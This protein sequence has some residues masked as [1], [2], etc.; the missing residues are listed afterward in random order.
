MNRD[1]ILANVDDV[2][3]VYQSALQNKNK[4]LIEKIF[5]SINKYLLDQVKINFF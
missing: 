5:K 1:K 2:A 3:I 4:F